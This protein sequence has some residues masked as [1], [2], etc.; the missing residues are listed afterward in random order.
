LGIEHFVPGHDLLRPGVAFDQ[1]LIGWEYLRIDLGPFLGV[2]AVP[3]L[4]D[5][6][7]TAAVSIGTTPA[8]TRMPAVPPV[9]MNRSMKAGAV[10]LRFQSRCNS[11]KSCVTEIIL[12][13]ACSMRRSAAPRLGVRRLVRTCRC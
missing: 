1:E 6:E 11:Q 4:L 9:W 7:A 3:G 12:P 10:S 8:C 2:A 13:P 5:S